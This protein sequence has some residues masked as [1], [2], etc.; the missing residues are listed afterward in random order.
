MI[1]IL[2]Y[3]LCRLYQ[4]LP[5]SVVAGTECT[6]ERDDS[7]YCADLECLEDSPSF[8]G[9]S[10]SVGEEDE[11]ATYEPTKRPT[12]SPVTD[13]PATNA[14]VTANPVTPSPITNS[15]SD[16]P[17]TNEPTKHPTNIPTPAPMEQED[18]PGTTLAPSIVGGEDD[19]ST[20]SPTQAKAAKQTKSTKTTK[21]TKKD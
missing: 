15:P 2:I 8:S 7:C 6:D 11:P 14:P 20:N 19:P 18:D 4:K 17:I 3:S 10:C 12:D 13:K 16:A 1:N 5:C 21:T 9:Y